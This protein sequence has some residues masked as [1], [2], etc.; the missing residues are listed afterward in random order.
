MRSTGLNESSLKATPAVRKGMS[1]R[2]RALLFGLLP[3]GL[4]LLAAAAL[5]PDAQ[6][7][8]KSGKNTKSTPKSTA[9]SSA[10]LANAQ[11]GFLHDVLPVVQKYCVSCHSGGNPEAGIDLSHYKDTASVLKDGDNW[12]RVVTAVS[13]G[14]MPP[15]N[16]PAPT[17]VQR[18]TLVAWVQTTSSAAACQLHD[19]GHVTLRRLNRAEYNNTVRDL[20]GVDVHP[21]DSFPND[22]VGY[23]FD[24]IGDVLS[25]SPLLM[26][27]YIGAAEKMAHAAFQNPDEFI[28]PTVFDPPRMVYIAQSSNGGEAASLPTSNSEAGADYNAPKDA[29]YLLRI[30]AYQDKAGTEDAKMDLKVDGKQVT[31]FTVAAI[32]RAPRPYT[33]RVPLTAGK[34]RV[35]CVFLNDFYNETLPAN[36]RDRNLYLKTI[37]VVGP[38]GNG[39]NLSVM[40]KRL[41][42]FEPEE[43]QR[44][45]VA[46]KFLNDFARRAY[47]RP[48][49]K[50][51][52]DPLVHYVELAMKQGDTFQKGVELAMT[53]TMC[54]PNFL[55]RVES[56]ASPAPKTAPGKTKVTTAKF[57]TPAT[58]ANDRTLLND[59]ALA[60]RLSYFL[61]SSMPD[62][63]LFTLAANGRL[64]DSTV[65]AAQ[66][67]RMLKDP[68]ARALSDNFAGQWLQLRS[69]SNLS[70]DTKRFPTFNEHLRQSMRTETEMY[71][72][73]IVAEDRSVL[74]FLTSNYTF[75]N[76]P[77]AKHYGI[78]NV[79]GEDFRKVTL[80]PE[81]QRGGLLTQ[82]SLLTVT[83]NPT[84]TSP[85]KRG[86]FVM[87]NLM[88]TPLPPAPAG[89]PPLSDDKK[90]PLVGTLRQR[91]EQHR[92]N[93][94]CA[95]CHARMDPIGFGLENFNAVGQWRTQ[96]GD[97]TIDPSGVLPDGS[98][99]AGPAE[100]KQIMMNKK[101]L[102]VHC[103]SEKLMTYALGR[104]VGR[105]D[106]CTIDTVVQTTSKNG[107]KFSA[108]VTAIVLSDPFRKQRGDAGA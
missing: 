91:M 102:F 31:Q 64:Q 99:F 88:G 108:L 7:Q 48:V 23:G 82:A 43:G 14:H 13:S 17:K 8:G 12:D 25:I 67:K 36:R 28:K 62:E 3:T 19:P 2:T 86:K 5:Q 94:T 104:G 106:K 84:R 77:L 73:N 105:P 30:T 1:L 107:Y 101:S 65:L 50:E 89:V 74:E 21:A 15:P 20:C 33:I 83:S 46:R 29:D 93:P 47:R 32:R 49:A 40:Q 76:E 59:F 39:D 68:R 37:E 27:K 52:V 34:H 45:T 66:V 78:D 72:Q 10:P 71:F 79:Q 51:E 6:A 96:D 80:A 98:K 92:L 57:T 100:L 95:S 53:A 35:S 85:V 9:S 58:D 42:T 81:T 26:E 69:L 87:E 18:D 61:W 44:L 55:F 97:S 41:G 60:S 103:L 56:Y 4:L 38:M 22:D 63:E 54:S 16:L 70:P 24:N 75:L 90:G 11:A